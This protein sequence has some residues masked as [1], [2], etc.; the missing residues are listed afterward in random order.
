ML[1][2]EKNVIETL[3]GRG[4]N[5]TFYNKN[6]KFNGNLIATLLAYN[7]ARADLRGIVDLL[8]DNGEHSSSTSHISKIPHSV[9]LA[10]LYYRGPDLQEIVRRIVTASLEN[11]KDENKVTLLESFQRATEAV[12]YVNNRDQRNKDVIKYFINKV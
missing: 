9:V 2:F 11:E 12:H 6:L 7:N 3:I 10:C 1:R 8:N 5:A 4:I